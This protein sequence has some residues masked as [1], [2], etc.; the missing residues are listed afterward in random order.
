MWCDTP[1]PPVTQ[2]SPVIPTS[3]SFFS[4]D[5]HRPSVFATSSALYWGWDSG[6]AGPWGS[7]EPVSPLLPMSPLLSDQ[8]P[9]TPAGGGAEC[10]GGLGASRVL[11]LG[12]IPGGGC[13]AP[14]LPVTHLGCRASVSLCI[15]L[16]PCPG[17]LCNPCCRAMPA[18]VAARWL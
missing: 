18:S 9:H 16:P 6:M 3:A 14:L 8:S 12:C 2:P 15:T 7:L 13:H 1:S 11:A 17:L 4:G 5:P 10:C